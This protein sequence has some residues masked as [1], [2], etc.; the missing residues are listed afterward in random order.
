MVIEKETTITNGTANIIGASNRYHGN[1]NNDRGRSRNNYRGNNQNGYR[2]DGNQNVRASLAQAID[3]DRRASNS[4][5]T[6]IKQKFPNVI[7]TI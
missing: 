1:G 5:R 6:L 4:S 7:P 3:C 2:N